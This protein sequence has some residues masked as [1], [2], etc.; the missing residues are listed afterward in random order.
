[1]PVFL[2]KFATR[3]PAALQFVKPG[4][5]RHFAKPGDAVEFAKPGAAKFAKPGTV[6]YRVATSDPYGYG[7]TSTVPPIR[8][9]PSKT[10]Q[11][12]HRTV[13]YGYIQGTGYGQ[14][15]LRRDR[16]PRCSL[17]RVSH[18]ARA[19]VVSLGFRPGNTAA[20][21]LNIVLGIPPPIFAHP[22]ILIPNCSSVRVCVTL[23]SRSRT[24][25][26]SATG[27]SR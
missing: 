17:A 26:G 16:A 12:G 24:S 20:L 11:Y 22:T 14:P 21:D 9:A 23:S 18:L 8:H 2:G 13:R 15:L 27:T 7:P 6:Q 4:A 25:Y 3:Y 1:M 10:L 5:Y 19:R